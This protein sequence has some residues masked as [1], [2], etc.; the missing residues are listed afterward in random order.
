MTDRASRAAAEWAVQRPDLDMLPMEVLGRLN[1]ASQLIVRE[2]QA[3]I[4]SHRPV[5]GD[6]DVVGRHDRTY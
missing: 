5:R 3:P 1:E 4:F 2:R 6:H